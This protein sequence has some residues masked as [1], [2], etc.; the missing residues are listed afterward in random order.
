MSRELDFS[1]IDY[2]ILITL[3]L[4]F[5]VLVYLIVSRAV[6]TTDIYAKCSYASSEVVMHDGEELTC[7]RLHEK[8][9]NKHLLFVTV[10]SV[11]G[12]LVGGS[13]YNNDPS[14]TVFGAGIALGGMLSLIYSVLYNW[15]YINEDIRIMILGSTLLVLGYGST[16]IYN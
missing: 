14:T 13:L 16:Q 7:A 8:T 12:M 6:N 1:S 11:L 9:A 3:G 5:A 2:Y 10:L 15:A 4:T